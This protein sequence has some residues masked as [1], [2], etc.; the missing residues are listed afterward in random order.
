M[1]RRVI[2]RVD[3]GERGHGLP[4]VGVIIAGAGALVLAIGAANDTGVTAIIGGVILAAGLLATSVMN[5]MFVE[6]EFYDRLD[7][8][9]GK[10]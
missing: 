3:A 8:L 2:D 4:L 7:K 1:D 6:Y 5:H 10:S 9:D